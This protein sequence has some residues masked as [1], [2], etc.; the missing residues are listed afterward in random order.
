MMRHIGNLSSRLNRLLAA[1]NGT[2]DGAQ[3]KKR[4]EARSN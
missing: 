4:E 1:E 3:K 2:L